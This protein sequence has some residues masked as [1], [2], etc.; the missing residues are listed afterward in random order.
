MLTL[1]VMNI[2][3]LGRLRFLNRGCR[4]SH[5]FWHV[6]FYWFLMYLASHSLFKIRETLKNKSQ[7]E[8][9]ACCVS[10]PLTVKSVWFLHRGGKPQIS[11]RATTEVALK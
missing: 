5:Q 8:P 7:E 10:T 1:R 3:P 9:E 2:Y 6:C 4:S 11:V